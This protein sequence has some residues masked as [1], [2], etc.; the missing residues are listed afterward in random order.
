MSQATKKSER[1][2]LVM[3]KSSTQFQ[4]CAAEYPR[5]VAIAT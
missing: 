1:L 5:N 3:L 2:L 4:H